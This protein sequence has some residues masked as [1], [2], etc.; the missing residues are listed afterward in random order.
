[1]S[2]KAKDFKSNINFDPELDP[3]DEI[4]APF[5]KEPI[6]GRFE[7]NRDTLTATYRL[8]TRQPAHLNQPLQLLVGVS[9]TLQLRD[10]ERN[11]RNSLL[12]K[13][14]L[15]GRFELITLRTNS[16]HNRNPHQR[17]DGAGP[18]RSPA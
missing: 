14:G 1:M 6:D 18:S 11:Y 2:V 8:P 7:T 4:L 9:V 3:L 12:F 16:D 17:P 10:P 15:V 13:H 5:V